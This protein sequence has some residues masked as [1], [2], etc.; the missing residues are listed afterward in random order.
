MPGEGAPGE[1][2]LRPKS[3]DTKGKSIKE[4]VPNNLRFNEAMYVIEQKL[5]VEIL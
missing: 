5:H 2:K 3:L 4:M 1:G